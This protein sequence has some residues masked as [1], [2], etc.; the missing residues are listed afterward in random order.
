MA[1]GPG[2]RGSRQLPAKRVYVRGG[3]VPFNG[4]RRHALLVADIS[5]NRALC[6]TPCAMSD[7]MME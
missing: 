2:A 5:L 4:D 3:L 7:N 6:S 1:L